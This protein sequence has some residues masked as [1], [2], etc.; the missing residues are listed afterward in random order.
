MLAIQQA[1]FKKGGNR[2]MLTVFS[3]N[4]ERVSLDEREKFVLSDEHKKSLYVLLSN[5]NSYQVVILSTC[6]RFEVYFDSSSDSKQHILQAML[7]YFNLTLAKF[8]QQFV[9]YRDE[10]ALKHLLHVSAGLRAHVLGETQVLGQ[11]KSAYQEAVQHNTVKKSFHTIFQ[12]TFRFCKEMHKTIG[13]NDHAVSLSYSAY[14]FI[15]THKQKP[16]TILL[17]GAGKMGQLFLQY[18]LKDRTHRLIV[19]NRDQS[20][21]GDLDQPS[22]ITGQLSQ[23]AHYLQSVDVVVSTLEL[24]EPLIKRSDVEKLQTKSSLLMIDLSMPRSIQETVN[25]LE[26]IE[27]HDLDS[28]GKMIDRHH[29]VRQ[30]KARQMSQVIDVE[31]AHIQNELKQQKH[32]KIRHALFTER[33]KK[34][35]TLMTSVTTQLPDLSKK[36]QTVI[37][38]HLKEALLESIK[39]QLDNLE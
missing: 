33:D 27:L 37:K 21:L 20:K 25:D 1:I 11:V 4:N 6:Q 7:S 26:H 29:F 35:R 3:V 23:W 16:Q 18:H 14:Q 12:R 15:Q 34:L 24:N 28:L 9:C 10:Q 2:V 39:L 32:D 17:L 22:I 19:L 31:V 36:E 38:H 13:I 30:Q 5:Q 8:E